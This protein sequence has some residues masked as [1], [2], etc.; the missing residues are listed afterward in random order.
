MM[1]IKLDGELITDRPFSIDWKNLN[2]LVGEIDEIKEDMVIAHGGDNFGKHVAAEYGGTPEGYVKSREV[3]LKLSMYV[4]SAFSAKG[5]PAVVFSPSSFLFAEGGKIKEELIGPIR[6]AI[7]KF[8]P[9]IHE[10]A[11]IDSKNGYTFVSAEEVMVVL[12]ETVKPRKILIATDVPEELMENKIETIKGS[13][14]KTVYAQLRESTQEKVMEWARLS[15]KCGCPV[16]AFDG[17]KKGE[18]GKAQVSESGIVVRIK[19]ESVLE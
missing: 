15:A 13:N 9:V 12:A 2:R 10:D 7:G 14:F 18:L 17:R 19:D 16:V 8:I 6:D 1:F 3:T 5:V 4:V 11:V